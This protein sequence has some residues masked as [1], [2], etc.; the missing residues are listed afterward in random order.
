MTSCPNTVLSTN[1]S[2]THTLPATTNSQQGVVLQLGIGAW[3]YK[4]L[5]LETD[6]NMLKNVKNLGYEVRECITYKRD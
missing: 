3:G 2:F 1:A 5:I 4:I 6:R